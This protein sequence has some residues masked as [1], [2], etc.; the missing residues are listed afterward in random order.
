MLRLSIILLAWI[1]LSVAG[2]M[3]VGVAEKKGLVSLALP[4][5]WIIGSVIWIGFHIADFVHLSRDGT[6][7]ASMLSD[8]ISG[9]P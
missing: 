9:R 4:I 6:T 2:G 5:L 3:S 1:G 7:G 8:E